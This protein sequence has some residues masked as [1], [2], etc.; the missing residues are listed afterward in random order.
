MGGWREKSRRTLSSSYSNL[1][2]RSHETHVIRLLVPLFF[3]LAGVNLCA[4]SSVVLLLV[5]NKVKFFASK[6]GTSG[7]TLCI[8]FRC[9]TDCIA[10]R[11]DSRI[12]AARCKS[13]SFDYSKQTRN[14]RAAVWQYEGQSRP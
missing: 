1:G 12:A 7:L 13:A 14:Q 8:T 4:S 9:M 11:F 10:V 2:G 5:H 6:Q 3:H